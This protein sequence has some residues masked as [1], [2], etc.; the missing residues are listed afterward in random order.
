MNKY[1]LLLISLIISKQTFAAAQVNYLNV[2][3]NAVHFSI[4][5]AKA[6]T[7]PSCVIAETNNRFSV[8]L[9]SEA[10]RAMY[11][12]LITAMA[13]KQAV[14]VESAQDCADI[15]GVER[16]KG[17][18]IVPALVSSEGTSGKAMYLYKDDGVTKLGRILGR[19]DS[20]SLE[21]FPVDDNKIIGTYNMNFLSTKV[22]K[23]VSV[24]F[25]STTCSGTAYAL[26]RYVLTN[27]YF[28]SGNLSN[29]TSS[30]AIN[31]SYKSILQADGVCKNE[32][33]QSRTLYP[34]EPYNFIC[35]NNPCIFK[36]E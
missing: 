14:T 10:G 1:L 22:Y 17:L 21:Y 12:L 26:N 18:S 32:V 20:G 9:Q 13:S 2:D 27:P 7:S 29:G 19:M 4:S 11:S 28:N 16:A 34:L 5:E 24:V 15:T 25:K 35:G 6:I 3:G 23:D 8:S 36:E 31:I 33:G 30:G